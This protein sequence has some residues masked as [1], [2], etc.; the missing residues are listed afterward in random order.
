M[1][2]KV[3]DKSG[4]GRRGFFAKR[5]NNGT[6]PRRGARRPSTSC[7]TK[8]EENRGLIERPPFHSGLHGQSSSSTKVQ[9]R[10]VAI[11]YTRLKKERF[12]D[13]PPDPTVS[14]ATRI[15][16]YSEH[17]KEH[18]DDSLSASVPDLLIPDIDDQEGFNSSL[19]RRRS[20]VPTE[21][22]SDIPESIVF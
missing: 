21:R 9:P 16:I 10:A 14:R 2:E 4:E 11:P 15:S 7:A 18:D 19:R 20:N 6:E 3:D 8:T 12:Y 5:R 1:R 17:V 22:P 13:W